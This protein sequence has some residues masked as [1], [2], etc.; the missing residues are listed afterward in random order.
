MQHPRLDPHRKRLERTV[1]GPLKR[2]APETAFPAIV[3]GDS[4]ELLPARERQ[5]RIGFLRI[6]AT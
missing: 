1:A 5:R 3:F 6:G 4:L 2:A